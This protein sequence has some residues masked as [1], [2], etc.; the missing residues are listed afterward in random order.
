MLVFF[1]KP[2]FYGKKDGEGAIFISWCKFIY[3]KEALLANWAHSFL[4]WTFPSVSAYTYFLLRHNRIVLPFFFSWVVWCALCSWFE[5]ICCISSFGST[6][7][8][9]SL[10]DPLNIVIEHYIQRYWTFLCYQSFFQVS[11]VSAF[12]AGSKAVY[13][14]SFLLKLQCLIHLTCIWWNFFRKF[15]NLEVFSSL[16]LCIMATKIWKAANHSIIYLLQFLV[17]NLQYLLETLEFRY[18]SHPVL[19]LC[20][21]LCIPWYLCSVLIYLFFFL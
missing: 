9:K 14:L 10:T 12:S 17:F 18:L 6:K 20:F 2:F 4:G 7:E 21:F 15:S 3:L 1:S 11:H 16:I 19:T 13:L 5:Y 8:C